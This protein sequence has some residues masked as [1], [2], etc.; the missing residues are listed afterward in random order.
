MANAD[1]A[2]A[3][4]ARKIVEKQLLHRSVREFE[5]RAVPDGVVG[6]LLDVVNRTATSSGLQSFSVVR[7]TDG[8]LR[9]RVA[10]ICAQDYVARA[11]ELFIFVAD[12]YRNARIARGR[13]YSGG[14]VGDMDR[15]F[16]GFTDAALAA[17]N[18]TNAVEA[19]D[20]GAVY[21]GSILNDAQ[22][23]IDLL[24][25]PEYT[26]PVVGV[27]FGYPAQDPQ[28]KP[29]MPVALK[30]FENAYGLPEGFD[31][32]VADYDEVMTGYYDTRAGGRRSDSFSEQLVRRL[33]NTP[34]KRALLLNVVRGQGFDLMLE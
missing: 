22:A 8:E 12:A 21:F 23:V 5:E 34:E 20:M 3:A 2:A 6:V 27:G 28:L 16:Q 33:A 14:A 26:F 29:R 13:G 31:G 4:A 24:G 1:G 18:L 9:G 25:L 17:Q 32:A 11:A 19:L 7:V 15:F 30:V 10:E